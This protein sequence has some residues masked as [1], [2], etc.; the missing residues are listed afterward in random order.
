MQSAAASAEPD[1]DESMSEGEVCVP[2][3]SL[4]QPDEKNQM[5]TPAVGDSGT[6][7][8]DYIVTRIEGDNAYVTPNAVNGTSLD[9]NEDEPD[10]DDADSG[11]MPD[12]G[13]AMRSEAQAMS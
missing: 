1:G 11:G 12:E 8:V 9:D 13:D 10:T 5:Q 2:L 6:M 7:T 4:V 3:K